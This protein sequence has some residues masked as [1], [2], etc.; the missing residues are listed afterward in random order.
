MHQL[1][2]EHAKALQHAGLSGSRFPTLKQVL[3]RRSGAPR[4]SLSRSGKKSRAVFFCLGY[5]RFWKTPIHVLLRCLP[6]KYNLLWLRVTMSYHRFNNLREKF[7]GHLNRVLMKNVESEDY[8]DRPCN[9]P[10]RDAVME[11]F[12]ARHSLS[13]WSLFRA[14][15]SI[16][17]VQR[18]D[19]EK[20]GSRPSAE[21]PPVPE[22][23]NSQ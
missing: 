18:P 3:D 19:L 23:W 1:Y 6:N 15:A 12:A 2:P 5:S 22:K 13:I 8:R 16:L 9:C 4:Q 14:L 10:G 17:L 11:M 7:Q 20:A 21:C